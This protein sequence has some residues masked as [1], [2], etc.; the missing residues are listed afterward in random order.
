MCEACKRERGKR[1][2]RAAITQ[3]IEFYEMVIDGLNEKIHILQ[4]EIVSLRCGGG[5]GVSDNV[6][7]GSAV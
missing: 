3:N 2:A 1:L 5:G 7:Q 6:S 4:E